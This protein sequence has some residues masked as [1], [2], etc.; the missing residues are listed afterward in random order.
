[1]QL[2]A[3]KQSPVNNTWRSPLHHV[4]DRDDG[5]VFIVYSFLVYHLTSHD[6]P[7]SIQCRLLK[8]IYVPA[9][10]FIGNIK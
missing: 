5:D 9:E 8:G 3:L 7:L 4:R 1:M 6:S 10:H 2:T